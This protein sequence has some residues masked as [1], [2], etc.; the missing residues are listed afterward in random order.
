MVLAV[1]LLAVVSPWLGEDT[2]LPEM[3]HARGAG[4]NR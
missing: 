1:V 3:L 2:R 4:I